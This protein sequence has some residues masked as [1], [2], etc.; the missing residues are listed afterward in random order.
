MSRVERSRVALGLGA[1]LGNRAAAL[2]SA[3][4]TIGNNA[5]IELIGVSPVFE[6]D[7]VG[8]PEQPDYLNAV[9]VVETTL[10]AEQ[11]LDIVHSAEQQLS[12]TRKI[13]WAARTL[14]VD[15]LNYGRKVSGDPVLTL[16]HPRAAERAFVL[17]P[18]VAIDPDRELAGTGL[19]VAEHLAR[20]D[21]TELARVRLRPDL[22]LHVE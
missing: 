15:I 17:V 22:A 14:D 4:D 8:G 6:T 11:L 13:R 21:P 10:S 3:I 19:S 12:R 1:N 9:L 16:P 7:P 2:Q 5:G 20:L 18:W